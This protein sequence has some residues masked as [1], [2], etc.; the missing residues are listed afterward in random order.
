MSPN[1]ASPANGLR[2]AS[3]NRPMRRSV[4]TTLEC[5]V[6]IGDVGRRRLEPLGGQVAA[7][8]DHDIGRAAQRRAADD[9]RGRAAGAAA[10]RDGAGV[11]LADLD[12][13]DRH[14]QRL[15]QDLR[16]HRLVALALALRADA[17]HQPVGPD[18]HDDMLVG[19]AAGAVEMA[20]QAEAAPLARRFAG[21]AARGEARFVGRLERRFEQSDAVRG[22]VGVA[23]R[24]RIG[25]FVG[26]QQVEAAQVGRGAAGFVRGDVDQAFEQEQ[27]LGL[28]GAADGID[29]HGV[30]EGA[31]EVDADRRDAV[32]A[33]DHLG[34]AGGRDGRG[35]HRDIGAV[36]GLSLDPEREELARLHRAPA[37]RS[38]RDRGRGCRPAPARRAR[39]SSAGR[40]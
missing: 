40:A 7:A 16:K 39:R 5:A 1:S 27:R 35:E 29:R 24:R 38:P 36:I 31:V 28:A 33:G 14:A 25:H 37:R 23:A 2:A 15:R 19:D 34:Q 22:V 18:L 32:E 4:P 20:G 12:A 6:A 21:G 3:S 13:L 10:V 11:A 26:T 8:L 9:G 17:G 30:A